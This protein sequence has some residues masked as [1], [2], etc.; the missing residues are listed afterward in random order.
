[1]STNSP[2]SDSPDFDSAFEIAKKVLR[3]VGEYRL[4][5]TPVVYEVLYRF[6]EGD[7]GEIGRQLSHA[8][9]HEGQVSIERIEQL[10]QQYCES[11]DSSFLQDMS[12][13]LR[14]ETRDIQSAIKRQIEVDDALGESAEDARRKLQLPNLTHVEIQLRLADLIVSNA[15]AL[16]QLNRTRQQLNESEKRVESLRQNL[17]QSTKSAITDPLTGV[18]NRRYFDALMA[19]SL[20]S[21]ESTEGVPVLILVDIDHFK[22][23][24]DTHGHSAGDTVLSYIA[25]TLR[26]FR[27]DFEIA[28]YG[29]DEFAIFIRVAKH[30]EA[31]TIAEDIR[32]LIA[33]RRL[34]FKHTGEILEGLSASIGLAHLRSEDTDTSWF[35]RADKLLYNAKQGGRNCVR[36]E[37]R[38]DGE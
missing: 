32:E 27:S 1:M 13:S 31:L 20:N 30:P 19:S 3:L 22:S 29:G 38:Y 35:E 10:H 16:E 11:G 6:A 15:A 25:N 7:D 9:D 5:P 21:R 8:I 17:L 33:T 2:R 24:N 37:R 28:R 12:E 36:A 26:A 18:G 4:A 14:N 23:I 34:R